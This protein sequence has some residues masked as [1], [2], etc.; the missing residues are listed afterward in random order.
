MFSVKAVEFSIC[1]RFP[2]MLLSSL[3]HHI[4]VEVSLFVCSQDYFKISECKAG[5]LVTSLEGKP[6]ARFMV[7]VRVL[8][9]TECMVKRLAFSNLLKGEQLSNLWVRNRWPS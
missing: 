6:V 9:I 4:Y 2:T 8:R 3:D 5:N 7:M 1:L